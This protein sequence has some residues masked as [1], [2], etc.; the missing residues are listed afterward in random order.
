MDYSKRR[1]V[2][3]AAAAAGIDP[4]S[5]REFPAFGPDGTVFSGAQAVLD[6]QPRPTAVLTFDDN[7]ACMLS[8]K[9][10]RHAGLQV[11]RDLSIAS[12]HQ[13]AWLAHVE[14]TLTTVHFDFF[15]AG[16]Q[17]AEALNR[18]AM[19]GDPV[20]DLRFEPTL[21]DGATIGPAPSA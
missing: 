2:H 20:T 6:A 19:T 12:F 5:I 8:F 11:P 14:P 4:A 13:W 18:A 10:R 21:I 16:R 17:A 1:G 3:D 9:A 15:A 7:L